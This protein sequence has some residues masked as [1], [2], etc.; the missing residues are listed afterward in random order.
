MS[1]GWLGGFASAF[2]RALPGFVEG[3]RQA[4]ADNWSDLTNFNNV[5]AGQLKNAYEEATFEP[6]VGTQ[7]LLYENGKL[8]LYDHSMQ[9]ALGIENFPS[10]L[11]Q[12]RVL[13]QY[14]PELAQMQAMQQLYALP[15]QL[16][17]YSRLFN[18]QGI[19]GLT[20]SAVSGGK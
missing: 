19:P 13:G 6:R 11:T 16:A 4:N 17:Y 2:G 8:G 15:L 10:Y 14:A 1:F 5:Q 12:A 18:G 7:N 3:D 9:T 20:P